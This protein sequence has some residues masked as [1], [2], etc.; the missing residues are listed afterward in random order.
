MSL[1]LKT[2]RVEP[3]LFIK[4]GLVTRQQQ[5]H[6][7]PNGGCKLSQHTSIVVELQWYCHYA[8]CMKDAVKDMTVWNMKT[9]GAQI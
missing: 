4:R 8:D 1:Y 3:L 7:L 2:E 6:L 5:L 9:T